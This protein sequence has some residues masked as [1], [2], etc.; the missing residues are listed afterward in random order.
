MSVSPETSSLLQEPKGINFQAP[1][2][3]DFGSIFDRFWTSP[4]GHFHCE[5]IVF[6]KDFCIRFMIA[7]VTDLG[8]ILAPVLI[9]NSF[10]NGSEIELERYQKPGSFFERRPRPPKIDFWTNLASTWPPRGPQDGSKMA[11]KTVPK[12]SKIDVGS[13]VGSKADFGP[14]LD[15]FWVDFGPILDRFWTDFGS[16]LGWCLMCFWCCCWRC[17]QCLRASRSLLT[18][19]SVFGVF[20]MV[21]SVSFF[22]CVFFGLF[23][24]SCSLRSW[25]GPRRL[26]SPTWA[27]FG[28]MLGTFWDI[29]GCC[30]GFFT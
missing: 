22:R 27:E 10:Q 14:I 16:I 20:L 6:L 15:R 24:V 25:A 11:P 9:P 30:F 12:R 5:N 8:A 1:L 29:F 26:W 17:S 18:Q 3:I 4:G 23:S 19:V 2:L 28:A 7:L 13:E 21:F